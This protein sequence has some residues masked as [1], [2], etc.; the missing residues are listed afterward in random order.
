MSNY[1]IVIL[2]NLDCDFVELWT[3]CLK[4]LQEERSI[5]TFSKL[6]PNALKIT[7]VAEILCYCYGVVEIE[8][9]MKPHRRNKNSF[10]WSL[11][12]LNVFDILIVLIC[13]H[14]RQDMSEEVYCFLS[15][16]SVSSPVQF[17]FGEVLFS[18]WWHHHPKFVAN[19]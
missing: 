18:I 3:I 16:L 17:T 4:L 6:L 13:F 15:V 14:F 9:G 5:I 2:V 11:H 10:T 1:E 8:D 12:T 7:A 19:D